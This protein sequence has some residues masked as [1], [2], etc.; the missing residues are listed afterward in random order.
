V[1][2]GLEKWGKG[3]FGIPLE[4]GGTIHA[5]D[6]KYSVAGSG[7]CPFGGG[8]APVGFPAKATKKKKN[9][10]TGLVTWAR[11]GRGDLKGVFHFRASPLGRGTAKGKKSAKRIICDNFCS[12]FSIS[13]KKGKKSNWAERKF[14]RGRPPSRGRSLGFPKNSLDTPSFPRLVPFFAEIFL[15]F[16]P[17]FE[18]TA[19]NVLFVPV[20]WRTGLQR[21]PFRVCDRGDEADRYGPSGGK[22]I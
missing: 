2:F 1:G 17:T 13:N 18:L 20:L 14:S 3:G 12:S 19:G 9:V 16:L 7:A 4:E 11:A 6:V 10:A 8:V 22:N 21:R 15:P 5:R